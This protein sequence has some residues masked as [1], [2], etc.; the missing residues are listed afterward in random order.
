MVGYIRYRNSI[1]ELIGSVGVWRLDPTPAHKSTPTNDAAVIGP[2]EG[3]AEHHELVLLDGE[4]SKR[5]HVCDSVDTEL[6][7]RAF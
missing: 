6:V 4:I 3:A 2:G 7:V 1:G 5:W